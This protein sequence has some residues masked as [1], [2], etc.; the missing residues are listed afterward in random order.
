MNVHVGII[1]CVE[2]VVVHV[3]VG[4]VRYDMVIPGKRLKESSINFQKLMIWTDL[5][6]WQPKADSY[7]S[8]FCVHPCHGGTAS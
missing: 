8:P 3:I 5:T 7:F 1:G 6:Q 2:T 4:V